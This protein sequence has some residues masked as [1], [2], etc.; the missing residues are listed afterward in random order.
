MQEVQVLE[1]APL[2][3]TRCHVRR[4][5]GFL[6]EPQLANVSVAYTSPALLT[7]P[8]CG[9]EINIGSFQ[10]TQ[11]PSKKTPS[12]PLTRSAD[13]LRDRG[14]GFEPLQPVLVVEPRLVVQQGK[15]A[16][17]DAE[18]FQVEQLGLADVAAPQCHCVFVRC[19]RSQ[20]FRV[21]RGQNPPTRNASTPQ[22]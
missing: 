13:G 11:A 6:C 7:F 15:V 19:S 10:N 9:V 8:D 2:G 12:P 4:A 14:P 17:L 20:R 22:K 3:D 21:E 16:H 18:G 5:P 1:E